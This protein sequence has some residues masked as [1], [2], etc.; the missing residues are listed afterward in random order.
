M[1][2]LLL[3][4]LLLAVLGSVH[5]IGMC[6]GFALTLVHT[7]KSRSTFF[8]RQFLYHLGKT[9]SYMILGLVAGA[10]GGAI[11]ALF[12]GAQRIISILLGLALVWVGF[13]L[14]GLLKKFE[15]T[16]AHWRRLTRKM[17][18]LLQAGTKQDVF[19]LG[20][21]NGVLPCGMV[22]GGLALATASGSALGGAAVMGVFGMAT[23]P[24]LFSLASMGSLMRPAW[25]SRLNVANGIIVVLLG[26]LTVFRGVTTLHAHSDAHATEHMS[27]TQ[28]SS[29][30][31]GVH[32][33]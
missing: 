31:Q 15:P 8:R 22:Y 2:H 33:H 30:A 4:A 21:L 26:L 23:I 19:F 28:E 12:G 13:G 9:T 5:C 25:R 6:G 27:S 18:R 29:P 10:L 7:A 14:L 20:M 17:G 1:Q 11:G 3:S 24:A 16:L 32:N